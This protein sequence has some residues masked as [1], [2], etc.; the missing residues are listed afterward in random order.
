[1][2]E[3]DNFYL[4]LQEPDRS[5]F[6]AL[7]QLILSLD[8]NLTPEW[9]YKLPFFYFKGKMF[10][11]LWVHKKFKQ[12]YIGIMD[13]N[14]LDYPELLLEDRKKVKILLVDPSKDIDVKKIKVILKD[15]IKLL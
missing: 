10:C 3:L 1:M 12:P 13:G 9:K 11:Y 7:R 8:S 15:A 5:V 6:I 14:Q 2:K 4:N